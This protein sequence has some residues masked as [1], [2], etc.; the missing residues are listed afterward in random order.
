MAGLFNAQ[1]LRIRSFYMACA[2]LVTASTAQAQTGAPPADVRVSQVTTQQMAPVIRVP[3]TVVSR[4]DSRLSAQ[5]SGAVTWV[6]DIGTQV[7]ANDIVARIDD[8]DLKLEQARNLSEVK[9]LEARLLYENQ[10]LARYEQLAATDHAPQS[11]L[12]EARSNLAVV[13]QTLEQA[14]IALNATELALSRTEV[15]APFPGQVVARLL[16]VGEYASPGRDVVRLVD[17]LHVEVRAQ[18]PLGQAGTLAQGQDVMLI[19]A[20]GQQ[21]GHIRAVIAMGDEISRSREVRLSLSAPL[22]IGTAVDVGLPVGVMRTVTSVPRDALV[23]RPGRTYVWSIADDGT[24]KRV[25]VTTGAARDNWVEVSG[26]LSEGEKVVIRGGERL[27]PGQ[28][29]RILDS[30]EG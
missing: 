24:A 18:V 21:M 12:E 3:G 10:Q 30:M 23:L 15:R 27:R 19:S 25:A 13:T 4:N 2:V 16:Q 8:R 1:S 26:T 9:R 5:I 6:A 17:S 7:K 28:P 20:A 11:R 14:R 29:V 22:A